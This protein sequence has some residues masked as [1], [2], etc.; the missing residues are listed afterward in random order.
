LFDYSAISSEKDTEF[1]KRMTTEFGVAAIPV[2]VFF[3]NNNDNQ[4]VRLC[5][6]KTED[7][8]SKAGELLQKI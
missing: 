2:S 6:A 8:L 1:T 5:F 4:V 3:S 7:T